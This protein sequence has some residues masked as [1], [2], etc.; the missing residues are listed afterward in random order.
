VVFRAGL[1]DSENSLAKLKKSKYERN[2][3]NIGNRDSVVGIAISYRLDD[4]GVRVRVPIGARI[5]S[6]P[7]RPDRL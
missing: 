1:D 4:R 5:F 7:N 2:S 3:V 6:S